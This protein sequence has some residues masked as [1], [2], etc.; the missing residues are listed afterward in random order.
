MAKKDQLSLSDLI[1]SQEKS[2]LKM[3]AAIE[4]QLRSKLTAEN[5]LANESEE[6]LVKED[7]TGLNGNVTKLIEE[8]KNTNS[9]FKS[10][11]KKQDKQDLTEADIENANIQNQQLA[12]LTKIEE[13]TS[14]KKV[15]GIKP[16][17]EEGSTGGGFFS[18]IGKALKGIGGSMSG[19]AKNMLATAAALW[20]LSK[21]L[22]NF[23]KVEWESIGKAAASL[24][25][26]GVAAKVVGSSDTSKNMLAISAGTLALSFALQQFSKVEWTDIAKGVIAL[27]A[28]GL[29]VKVAGSGDSWKTVLGFSAGIIGL[30]FGLQ[31]FADVEWESIGKAGVVLLGLTVAVKALEGAKTGVFVMI[32][33][34]GAVFLIAKAMT[35]FAELDWT[36]IGKGLATIAG[37][38]LLGAAA[39]AAAPL[40]LA[41]AA[42]LGALGLAVMAIGEGLS[43]V[44][45]GILDFVGGLER[46]ATIDASNLVSVAAGIAAVSG[47]LLLFAGA[48]MTAALGNLVTNFLSLGQDSPVKQLQKIGAAGAGIEKA[49][50]GMERLAN[51]LKS[52]AGVD[53]KNLDSAV[54][55]AEKLAKTGIKLVVAGPSSPVVTTTPTSANKVYNTSVEAATAATSANTTK[56][57]TSVVSAPTTVNKTT[58]N[59]IVKQPIRNSESSLASYIKSRYAM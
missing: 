48:G 17:K 1:S 4:E 36:S 47:A 16:A 14:D 58:K 45:Q 37:I 46:L 35:T 23:K 13:N 57:T 51:A 39:G 18:N 55:A 25:G 15:E 10:W 49:A 11:L 7:G 50:I 40:L 6:A 20:I 28:L 3:S 2:N 26:L 22:D 54:N 8:L 59:T 24:L 5:K 27:T 42:A 31:K 43:Q 34:A 52:F 33:M 9:M 56:N 21:A 30:A 32:G 53:I 19:L 44:G 38:G 29:A 12:L 41:G